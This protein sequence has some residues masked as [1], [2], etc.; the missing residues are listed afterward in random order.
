MVKNPVV[1]SNLS[2]STL[3]AVT[4]IQKVTRG[5]QSRKDLRND[6]L[7]KAS[8]EKQ[9][10]ALLQNN[11]RMHQARK[12]VKMEAAQK[13]AAYAKKLTYQFKDAQKDLAPQ[14]TGKPLVVQRNTKELLL[15]ERHNR[16]VKAA[17]SRGLLSKTFGNFS[18]KFSKL[19]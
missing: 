16:G 14:H 15:K 10:A 18:L 2:N 7:N 13:I 1:S 3:K 6:I 17:Q 9:A 8:T 4:K 11:I 19:D 5:H 12:A